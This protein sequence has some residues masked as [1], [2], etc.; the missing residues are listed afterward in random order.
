MIAMFDVLGFKSLCRSLGIDGIHQRYE[1]LTAYIREP[2]SGI[3]IVPV[4]GFVA[5][6]HLEVRCAYFSDT[7]LFWSDYSFPAFRSF[8]LTGRCKT[9]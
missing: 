4:G 1:K 8:S 2:K 7:V 5:V 3:D 6:G 9:G